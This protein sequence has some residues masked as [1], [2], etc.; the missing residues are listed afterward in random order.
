MTDLL[1]APEAHVQASELAP[2]RPGPDAAAAG[3]RASGAGWVVAS[4]LGG[5]ALIHAAMAPSHLGE[6]AI[7]GWGFV[8]AAWAQLLL[9]VAVL[10]RPGRRVGLA[11]IAT[12]TV[13]VAVWAVTRVAGLPFGAHA[14][15][16][17][18]VSIVDGICVAL[19]VGAIV[20]AAAMVRR[21]PAA[22]DGSRSPLAVLGALGA[23]VLATAAVVSPSARDHAAGSHGDHAHTAGAEPAA[24]GHDHQDMAVDPGFAALSNGHQHEHGQDAPLTAAERSTLAGELAATADLVARYPTLADAEAAGWR[25]S[26]PFSPGLG[27]HYQGPNFVLNT[28]G[29]MDPEDLAAPMLI[30]DGVDPDAPLAGFMYLAYGTQGEPAGFAGPNDHWHYHDH[31]CIVYGPDGIDTP[32]GADLE[33]VT[34]EM[35]SNVSGMWVSTTPYMVHVWNVPGYESP[36]GMFTELNPRITCPDGTYDRIAIEDTGSKNSVCLNP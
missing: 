29:D 14:G 21:S 5:A 27:V 24:G 2:A 11:V 25:R 30:F 3:D 26:G 13:L 32:F 16:A 15:H 28:D 1:D 12:N 35:C 17:E 34:E 19:E 31:V 36:D 4:C 10:L 22:A 33:G 6:S 23:L 9:A 8:V 7:E 18:S 20:L